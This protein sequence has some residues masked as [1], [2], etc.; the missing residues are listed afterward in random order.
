MD[1]N[2]RNFPDELGQKIRKL[3]VEEGV[4]VRAFVIGLLET[5][6]LGV[7]DEGRNAGAKISGGVVVEE[8]GSSDAGAG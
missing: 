8:S 6:I 3:A 7:Q 2:V 4:T 5:G 1:M